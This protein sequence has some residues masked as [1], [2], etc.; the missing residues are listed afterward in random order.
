[1]LKD[2]KGTTKWN[3]LFQSRHIKFCFTIYLK[4]KTTLIKVNFHILIIKA[5]DLKS[6]YSKQ[7]WG[8]LQI[9]HRRA[10][11]SASVMVAFLLRPWIM[12]A[13]SHAMFLW[14]GNT[15]Y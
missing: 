11:W 5:L 10:C 3:F 8:K 15:F 2:A 14:S 13:A 6:A 1:M 9:V 7:E 4:E 12:Q